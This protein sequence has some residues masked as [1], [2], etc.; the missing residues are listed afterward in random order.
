MV[1]IC[2]KFDEQVD[3]LIDYLKISDEQLKQRELIREMLNDVFKNF[4]D[5]KTLRYNFI[6]KV[7]I[8]YPTSF[9]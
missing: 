9:L 6:L 8:Y 4:W 1:S 5:E 7:F 3:K 2:L